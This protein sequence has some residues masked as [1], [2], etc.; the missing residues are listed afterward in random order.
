MKLCAK[1]MHALNAAIKRK[2]MGHL[3][4]RDAEQAREF[5]YK[6]LSGQIHPDEFLPFVVAWLEISQ[7]FQEL[8]GPEYLATLTE[9]ACPLC[10]IP[11]LLRDGAAD[12]I[13]LDNITDALVLFCDVNAIQRRG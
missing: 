4:P 3:E 11:K 7:K 10:H 2:G 5:T 6:W 8:A 9:D 12:E 13:W 1:H